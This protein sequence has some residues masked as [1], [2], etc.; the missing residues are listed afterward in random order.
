ML[1]IGRSKSLVYLINLKIRRKA[2]HKAFHLFCV[3]F[4]VNS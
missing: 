4:G 3:K 2:H 1:M